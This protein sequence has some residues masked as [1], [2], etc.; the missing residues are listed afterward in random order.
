M[1]KCTNVWT[2]FLCGL[3][4]TFSGHLIDVVSRDLLPKHEFIWKQGLETTS[5]GFETLQMTAKIK[6]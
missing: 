3:G 1:V 2:N 5:I 6:E 4:A